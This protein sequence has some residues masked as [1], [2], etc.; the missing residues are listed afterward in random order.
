M[1]L[2]REKSGPPQTQCSFGAR[3]AVDEGFT[4]I[5]GYYFVPDRKNLCRCSIRMCGE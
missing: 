3:R 2:L 4:G 5:F 1:A